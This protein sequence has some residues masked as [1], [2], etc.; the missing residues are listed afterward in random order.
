MV[1]LAGGVS[2]ALWLATVLASDAHW[3][4]TTLF[5]VAVGSGI[6]FWVWR[7]AKRDYTYAVTMAERLESALG[8]DEANEFVF[9]ARSFVGFEELEDEGACY[10]FDLGRR[11]IAFIVGQE[12]YPEARFP[13]LDFSLVYP[14]D[15]EGYE[16]D[17]LIEKRGPKAV[18]V[19]KI[20]GH[21]KPDYVM[22]GHL[23]VIE[24]E[25][26]ELERL[27]ERYRDR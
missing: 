17:M 23:Q 25:L 5:W 22:A 6:S 26:S 10:A 1:L 19:R 3:A 12:F 21:M 20:P 14:L 24:G 8:R 2:T 18:A 16:V 27:L 7:D 4:V 11:R 15:S 13:S 9:E